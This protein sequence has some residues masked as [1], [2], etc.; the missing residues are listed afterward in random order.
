MRRLVLMAG[1]LALASNLL[2]QSDSTK[3]LSWLIPTEVRVQYAG[4]IGA[5]SVGP[6]WNIFNENFNIHIGIGYTPV[7][8]MRSRDIF[9]GNFK[10]TY[11]PKTTI[12]LG[13]N[14]DLKPLVFGFAYSHT[15]GRRY[16]KYNNTSLY[17]KGYYWWDPANRFGF[18]YSPEINIETNNKTLKAVALYFETSIWDMGIY[19][20][21][22][23]GN[24]DQLN[25]YDVSSFGAGV[26]F[27]FY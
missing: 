21:T 1:L 17:E 3:K 9:S 13:N 8:K 4:N 10:L 14:F 24:R 19:T 5:V 12:R 15:Y 27:K 6:A 7:P 2:A 22:G 18:Y 16:N 20:L 11:T 23:N 26:R 25:F